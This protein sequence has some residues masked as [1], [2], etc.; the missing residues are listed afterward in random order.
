MSIRPSYKFCFKCRK[1]YSWNPDI[2]KMGCPYCQ[3][4]AVKDF[5]RHVMGKGKEMIRGVSAD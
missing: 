4:K 2:G 1:W 3:G 5:L